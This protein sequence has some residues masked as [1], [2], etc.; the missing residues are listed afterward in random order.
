MLG[1][2]IVDRIYLAAAEPERWPHTMEEVALAAGARGANLIRSTNDSIQ[3]VS[4]PAIREVTEQFAREGWNAQNSRVGRLLT[5]SDHPGF[6]TDSHLHSKKELETLPI[7]AGFLNP[8]GVSAGAATIIQGAADE[9]LI[10]AVEAFPDHAASRRAVRH[11]NRL[12]PH[13]AR[14]VA[15]SSQI[16]LMQARSALEAFECVSMSLAIL[17]GSGG[18]LGATRRFQ[19]SADGLLASG[20]KLRALDP[21]SDSRMSEA[22][23]MLQGKSVGASI[24]LRDSNGHGAAVLHLIPAPVKS[25]LLFSKIAGYALLAKPTSEM[26]P[27]ADVICALFDLTPAEARLARAIAEGMSPQEIAN[28][29]RTSLQTVRTQLKSVFKKTSVNRQAELAALL[30]K[31]R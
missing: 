5:R 30:A 29:S 1:D 31:L 24:A 7:Y 22:L 10:L 26:L 21:I 2:D 18:V 27:S 20:P 16:G 17:E 19:E 14:A 11:L 12:R 9:G 23:L 28:Q 13:L 8:H 4:S 15:L 25:T 6:L 3:L